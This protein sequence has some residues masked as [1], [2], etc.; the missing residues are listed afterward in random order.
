MS[1]TRSPVGATTRFDVNILAERNVWVM[2]S[3]YTFRPFSHKQR[4][5]RSKYKAFAAG[6]GLF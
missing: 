1:Y 3:P 4:K 2:V 6:A 5:A